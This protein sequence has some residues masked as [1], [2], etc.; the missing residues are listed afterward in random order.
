MYSGHPLKEGKET[1]MGGRGLGEKI[2]LT[3]VTPK[4]PVEDTNRSGFVVRLELCR[5]RRKRGPEMQFIVRSGLGKK[6][7]EVL[8][9]Q[10]PSGFVK[11]SGGWTEGSKHSNTAVFEKGRGEGRG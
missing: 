9:K 10:P 5:R 7:G 11:T 6:L 3:H 4:D 2:A 1:G 8:D